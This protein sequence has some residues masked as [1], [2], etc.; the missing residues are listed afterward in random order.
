MNSAQILLEEYAPFGVDERDE[1]L[2]S[3]L[4]ATVRDIADRCVRGAAVD[5]RSGVGS[6]CAAS[7]LW[8]SWKPGAI[9]L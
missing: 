1:D 4:E 5:I 8:A 9:E 3:M 7:E 2:S 6:T